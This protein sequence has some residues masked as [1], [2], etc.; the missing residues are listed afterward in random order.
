[1]K[2]VLKRSALAANLLVLVLFAACTQGEAKPTHAPSAGLFT[3]AVI[4][5]AENAKIIIWNYNESAYSDIIKRINET[6][7]SA[8]LNVQFVARD[9]DLKDTELKEDGT[10]DYVKCFKK[11][12]AAGTHAGDAYPFGYAESKPLSESGLTMDVSDIVRLYA[13]AYYAKYNGL[14]PD[15]LDCIP[16]CIE[17]NPRW[18][19][20][21]LM[22]RK[23]FTAAGGEISTVEGLF[24][25]LDDVI[26]TSDEPSTV[27]AD[28]R[29]L[30]DQ[31]ALDRGYYSLSAYGIAG[32]LYTAISDT[33]FT[34]V[35]L[36][37]IP[38]FED[39]IVRMKQYYRIGVLSTPWE[40][41]K[42]SDGIG[43]VKIIGQYYYISTTGTDWLMG[44]FAVQLFSPG[45]PSF[46]SEPGYGSELVIP[47]QSTKDKAIEVIRFIEWMNANQENY[48]SIIYG[49]AGIDFNAAGGRYSPLIDGK[50]STGFSQPKVFATWPSAQYFYNNDY[51]RLPLLAPAQIE[52]LADE[53]VKQNLRFPL[54]SYMEP[55]RRNVPD[56]QL[57]IS[58]EIKTIVA[59]RD[60]AMISIIYADSLSFNKA[61][62][63]SGMQALAGIKNEWLISQS[64]LIIQNAV[65]SARK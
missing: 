54:S 63:T 53:G 30:V 44:D 28:P 26:V 46:V 14:F 47:A 49:T 21:A 35:T 10:I 31:W 5:K 12:Q 56:N 29:T 16:M 25:F 57:D 6:L 23:D 27:L 20:T 51:I 3:P 1:M 58:E 52:Q 65:N 22:L 60:E 45:M 15:K 39:F 55:I 24:K 37:S 4:S 18:M 17:N 32:C 42:G 43:F 36:E 8:K 7:S 48:D 9:I 34:P 38:G 59:K 13:P 50:A 61:S 64:Q 62:L 40:G 2:N 33:Q 41:V 11:D 19:K